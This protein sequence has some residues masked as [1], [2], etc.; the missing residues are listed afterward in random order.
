MKPP[1]ISNRAVVV[2]GQPES[3]APLATTHFSNAILIVTCTLG[4][5]SFFSSYYCIYVLFF[6]QV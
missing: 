5:I 6:E 4:L 1:P 3:F 2:A